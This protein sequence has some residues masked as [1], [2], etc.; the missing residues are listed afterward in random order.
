MSQTF[1]SPSFVLNPAKSLEQAIVETLSYSDVFD[2]PLTFDELHKYLVISVSKEEIKDCL[3]N[4]TQI[5][6]SE[7]YYF[8]LGRDEIVQTRLSREKKSQPVFKRALVYG[9]IISRFPFVKMVALTG[10]LAML[11]LSNEIDMD[12]MLITKPNRLWLARAFAVT[13]GRIMR[14]IGDRICINLLI[15]EN[16]LHWK[17]HDL[18]SAR[19]ISQMIPISG[20]RIYND[21][22]V[23]NLWTQE[24]LPNAI[25][26]KT[27]NTESKSFLHQIFELP[28]LGKLGDWIENQV[29]KFQLKIIAKNFGDGKE[30]KFTSDICQGNFHQHKKWTMK[31]YEE[32]LSLL[33]PPSSAD[34]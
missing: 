33:H 20:L 22:R 13:F 4:T 23:A 1:V 27:N 7:G 21:F 11:N 14:L 29:M 17:D 8:L 24:F 30:T 10:S 12:F 34:D 31:Q 25:I 18:Y 19:E 3:E 28:L 16:A 32:R 15:S 5:N 26:Q 6:F 2:Y 9:N